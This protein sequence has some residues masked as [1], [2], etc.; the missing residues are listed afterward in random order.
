MVCG[1]TYD[2]SRNGG[3]C[4]NEVQALVL[5]PPATGLYARIKSNMEKQSNFVL[6]KFFTTCTERI[7][8]L[9][10]RKRIPEPVAR[11]LSKDEKC[12]CFLLQ[13]GLTRLLWSHSSPRMSLVSQGGYANCFGSP[14]NWLQ[15]LHVMSCS[16]IFRTQIE[17]V[18]RTRT[19][20]N[21]YTK[22]LGLFRF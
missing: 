8:W 5:N 20:L 19:E 10:F 11:I 13:P 16:T 1:T 14:I 22:V 7:L 4:S 18:F 9:L 6:D 3:L 17:E 21:Q 15:I 2:S 12:I